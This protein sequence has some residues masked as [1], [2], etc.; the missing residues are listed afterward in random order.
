MMRLREGGVHSIVKQRS[1]HRKGDS[2][3]GQFNK[4]G[5]GGGGGGGT[6]DVYHEYRCVWEGQQ[7]SEATWETEAS[8][9]EAKNGTAKLVRDSRLIADIQ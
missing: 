2:G 1:R 9:T 3:G 6:A 7:E 5:G 8:L 4:G